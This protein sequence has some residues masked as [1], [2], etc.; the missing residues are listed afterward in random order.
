MGFYQNS[1]L[2]T[3]TLFTE[4]SGLNI[5]DFNAWGKLLNAL[6]ECNNSLIADL[7]RKFNFLSLIRWVELIEI[8][9]VPMVRSA[10]RETKGEANI[11]KALTFLKFLES[12]QTFFDKI[13]RSVIEYCREFS[14]AEIGRLATA[15]TNARGCLDFLKQEIVCK[16][17]KN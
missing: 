6:E 3:S 11:K 7:D 9:Y 1:F 17:Q 14:D 4:V 8:E 13:I 5:A 2:E 12:F 16:Y 15:V 10:L